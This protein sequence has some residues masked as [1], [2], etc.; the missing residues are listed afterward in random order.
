[1]NRGIG[2]M[3][4]GFGGRGPRRRF[5]PFM[6]MRRPRRRSAFS[7]LFGGIGGMGRRRGFNPFMNR[8]GGGGFNPFER[9]HSESPRPDFSWLE[10]LLGPP[11]AQPT[12][13]TGPLS[14]PASRPGTYPMVETPMGPQ[15]IGATASDDEGSP[16]GPVG[17]PPM[18]PVPPPM[19][20]T[21]PVMPAA[22]QPLA[23]VIPEMSPA[24]PTVGPPGT[25]ITPPAPPANQYISP[26]EQFLMDYPDWAT[27]PPTLP[28][29][30]PT[31]G[32]K[33]LPPVAPATFSNSI[34]GLQTPDPV[35]DAVDAAV[36]EYVSPQDQFL[37]DYPDWATTPPTL[38][39]APSAGVPAVTPTTPLP[40]PTQNSIGNILPPIPEFDI[41]PSD[42]GGG[43]IE[44]GPSGGTIPGTNIPLPP[45][46]PISRDPWGGMCPHP[47]EEILL[48]D[49]SW[50]KAKDIQ[51][52]DKVK[53]LTA[54]DFK[55]GEYE[56]TRVE[57]IDNQPRCEVF[58]KDSKSIISSYSHPYAVEDKGFVEAQNIKT[59]DTVGD[60]IVTEVK[61]LDW[62]SV[63]SLSVDEAETYML[64]GGSEDK[65]VAVLSHNKSLAP[66][67][68]GPR[69]GEPGY[70][71]WRV[72]K[73]AELG[74]KWAQNPPMPGTGHWTA[75]QKWLERGNNPIPAAQAML[76]TNPLP[77]PHRP[78]SLADEGSPEAPIGPPP[79]G[80]QYGPQP[81]LP[82]MPGKE[83]RTPPF[84]GGR[85]PGAPLPPTLPVNIAQE[86]IEREIIPP[87]LPVFPMQQA[88]PNTL[89]AQEREPGFTGADLL[90]Q[91]VG[92]RSPMMPSVNMNEINKR[93]KKLS[94]LRN[95]PMQ[96]YSPGGF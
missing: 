49:D 53:T 14:D 40:L 27:N 59:G 57:I 10:Q 7:N 71:A 69:P 62:G 75:Y 68:A 32:G 45:N 54:K 89:R 34:E 39:P 83:P 1:M 78:P 70:E 9:R 50:I 95:T 24:L 5:N 30:G 92:L 4:G 88:T 48:A 36:N 76:E 6:G 22:P 55:A 96:H 17:P 74:Q 3:F 28:P 37:A 60:L 63:V 86:N 85:G 67:T 29:I 81:L 18:A 25:T 80:N 84:I 44:E 66:E 21:A 42:K 19:E 58:F 56:I 82:S 61:P 52:G 51:V 15:P 64:K 65:P 26:Q 90:R 8:F 87:Q 41:I 16:E 11:T 46:M 79:T 13:A 20:T 43:M 2:G 38:P 72:K 31:G 35:Q 93:L 23:P 12:P 47:N 33:P 91:N 73:D 94:E 77:Q